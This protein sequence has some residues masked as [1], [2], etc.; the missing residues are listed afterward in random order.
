MNIVFDDYD[1]KF[2]ST[3]LKG[4]ENNINVLK[5]LY[6]EIYIDNKGL[7]YS[8]DSKI[9]NGRVMCQTTLQNTI[10]IPED[11]LL[12]INPRT[13][14][15]CLKAGKTKILGVFTDEDNNLI[16]RTTISDYTVGS[17]E[18]G[19]KLNVEFIKE[20]FNN[21]DYSCNIND[22]LERFNNK[23]FVNT[24]YGEYDLILTHKLFPMINK[25]K[26]FDF[27]AKKNGD[28]TF[29]GIFKNKIE[30]R[31]KKDEII[32][33]VTVNYIYKFMDLN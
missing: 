6:D 15:E 25:C 8:I 28:G 21:I 22:L 20:M 23:E 33:E 12:K 14:Y 13:V 31:N 4:V 27:Y 1:K 32:F 26:R 24:K 3:F 2:K 17:F 7:A 29:Y 30:E 9:H 19:K 16:F 5:N 10:N 11:T 18:K